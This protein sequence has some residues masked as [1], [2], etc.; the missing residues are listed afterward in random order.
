MEEKM[1]SSIN[2][3]GQTGYARAGEYN[4][5]FICNISYAKI[6]SNKDLN[7]RPETVKLLEENKGEMLLDIGN[8]FFVCLYDSLKLR[9][10]KQ[11][12]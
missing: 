12:K 6:N 7:V 5:T 3:V 1:V 11:I 4:W 2:A 10:E 8:D 9:P